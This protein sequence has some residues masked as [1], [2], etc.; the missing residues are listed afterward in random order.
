MGFLMPKMPAMPAP[1]IAPAEPPAYN[2]AEK[3]AEVKRKLDAIERN[4]MGRESTILTTYQGLDNQDLTTD[5][6]TLLGA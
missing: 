6:K 1:P 5:K 3:A 2:D 4:R